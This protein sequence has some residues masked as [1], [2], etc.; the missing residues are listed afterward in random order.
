MSVNTRLVLRAQKRLRC[1]DSDC[2]IPMGSAYVVR[3]VRGVTILRKRSVRIV[4]RFCASCARSNEE[5]REELSAYDVERL[6][7]A[8]VLDDVA[9]AQREMRESR[10]FD[11]DDTEF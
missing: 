6:T 11:A 5:I 2:E 8:F 4:Q 1:H 7:H 9:R 3:E 10:P